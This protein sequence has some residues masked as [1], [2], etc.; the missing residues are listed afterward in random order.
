[1]LAKPY[2]IK[3]DEYFVINGSYLGTDISWNSWQRMQ[4]A[5]N[6][7]LLM[8]ACQQ[9]YIRWRQPL[10]WRHWQ[11]SKTLSR[12]TP[13]MTVFYTIHNLLYSY[14]DRHPFSG[15]KTSAWDDS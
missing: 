3:L 12:H 11:R 4:T 10:I 13:P 7:Q 14:V 2:K 15:Q 8:C 9:H 1:L 6:W 5:V